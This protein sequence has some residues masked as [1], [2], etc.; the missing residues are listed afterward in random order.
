[1]IVIRPT[2]SSR[3]ELISPL[4]SRWREGASC[5]LGASHAVG[6]PEQECQ[7]AL[8]GVRDG[9]RGALDHRIE[10]E[11][12]VERGPQLDDRPGTCLGCEVA[13]AKFA[14]DLHRP[15]DRGQRLA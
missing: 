3:Y 14:L 9:P 4:P 2:S 8:G 12:A 11:Q 5:T 6:H 7:A 1:M 13:H 15:P 10:L